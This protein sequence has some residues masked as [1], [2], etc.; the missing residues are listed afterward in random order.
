MGPCRVDTWRGRPA[1]SA[2]RRSSAATTWTE[3][4]S[5]SG[6]PS[7]AR[8]RTSPEQHFIGWLED[9]DPEE[10]FASGRAWGLAVRVTAAT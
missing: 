4:R 5:A 3:H 7:T 8:R 10:L 2:K 1:R 9:V 6:G